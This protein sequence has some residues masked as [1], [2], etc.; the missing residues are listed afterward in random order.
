MK[1]NIP[2]EESLRHDLLQSRVVEHYLALREHARQ[3]SFCKLPSCHLCLCLL[4]DA[5]VA[6]ALEVFASVYEAGSL[7][8]TLRGLGGCTNSTLGSIWPRLRFLW[9][10]S[11][12]GYLRAA[13]PCIRRAL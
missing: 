8:A 9:R 3:V 1:E 6:D 2:F 11:G 13:R 7:E 4:L 10:W 12:F 5:L